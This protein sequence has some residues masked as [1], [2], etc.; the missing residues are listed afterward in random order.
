MNPSPGAVLPRATLLRAAIVL[1]VWVLALYGRALGYG[2]VYDDVVLIAENPALADLATLPEALTH[3]L[4]HFAD[5]RR[6]T[7]YWRPTVTL[8]YYVDHLLGGGAP[9]VF[10]LTNLLSL[11]AMGLGLWRLVA[12]RVGEAAAWAVTLLFLA[13]PL[14]VEGAVNVAG[15]TD[16]LCGA[17]L[18]WTVQARGALGVGLGTLIGCGAKELGALAPALVALLGAPGAWRASAAVVALWLGARGV[19]LSGE[20]IEAAGPTAR[21]VGEAGA[22]AA[23]LLTRALAPTALAPGLTLPRVGV[24]QAIVGWIAVVALTAAASWRGGAGVRA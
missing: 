14:Q 18:I 11:S 1:F 8:S 6:A 15:R 10:H 20:V 23:W 22:R 16:L 9:W 7:P 13:H 17:A 4:F 12:T 24:G 2:F 19:V 21:S 3:E 5:G